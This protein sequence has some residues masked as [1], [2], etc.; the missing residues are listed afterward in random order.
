[1]I[2]YNWTEHLHVFTWQ[3][4]GLILTKHPQTTEPSLTWAEQSCSSEQGV[5]SLRHPQRRHAMEEVEHRPEEILTA[6]CSQQQT[7]N[8]SFSMCVVRS[9]MFS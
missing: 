7:G 5:F 1:M 8:C 3:L 2:I 6:S 4:I 9:K